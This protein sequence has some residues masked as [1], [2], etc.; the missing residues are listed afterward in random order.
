LVSGDEAREV[1][2]KLEEEEEE[3]DDQHQQVSA[4]DESQSATNGGGIPT[5]G[6][7]HGRN[8]SILFCRSAKG[9]TKIETPYI[10]K[11]SSP[12]PC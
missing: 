7:P 9:V 5:W 2:N 6:P 1:E 8:I 4:E 11:N 12:C 3:Y 10:N